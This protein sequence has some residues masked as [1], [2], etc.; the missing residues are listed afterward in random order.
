MDDLFTL[1]VGGL[2][3]LGN[4]VVLVYKF[5]EGEISKSF[6]IK[7]F[8]LFIFTGFVFWYYFQELHNKL[9]KTQIKIVAL[10]AFLLFIL[11][12]FFV[13]YFFGTPQTLRSFKKDLK[14][15]RSLEMICD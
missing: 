9:N 8:L 2:I 6:V 1:F 13:F 3:I 10:I 7:S 15:A 4:L 12:W 11:T 14:T 5:L